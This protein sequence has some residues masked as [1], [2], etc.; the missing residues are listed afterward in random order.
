MMK[1]W[2]KFNSFFKPY[3]IESLRKKLR[4]LP[5]IYQ[6]CVYPFTTGGKFF[7][8]YLLYKTSQFL[9]K[10]IN[11]N[12]DLSYF[13]PFALALELIHNYSLIHDDLPSMDNADFRR[14]YPSVHKKFGEAE[15][16]LAGDML[17]T[18]A[19]E[20]ISEQKYFEPQ[21]ILAVIKKVAQYSSY[22]YLIT[23]QYLDIWMQRNILDKSLENIKLINLYNYL[24]ESSLFFKI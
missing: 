4:G 5:Q 24:A 12:K 7:R 16:I 22:K 2:E 20:F 6:I 9:I 14:G 18:L 13:L 1:D 17:L 3:C 23:G 8:S 21:K 10:K 15:A 11:V 19:F